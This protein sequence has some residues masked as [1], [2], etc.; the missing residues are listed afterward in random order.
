MD[1]R[2]VDPLLG[3]SS[4]EAAQ[5]QVKRPAQAFPVAEAPSYHEL[6]MLKEPVWTWTIPAYFFVGGAAGAASLLGG[7]LALR[8]EEASRLRRR[9]R[10]LA[11]GGDVISAGLLIYD[12]G[13]PLRFL[14][15]LRVFRPSS[16]MSVGSWILTASGAAN[17]AAALF[18]G[19]RGLLGALGKSGELAGALL[20]MPLA[21]YTA[22]LLSTTAVPVWRESRRTLP[23]LFMS[24]GVAAAAS[25]LELGSLNRHEE[26]VLRRYA[27]AGKAGELAATAALHREAS[28]VPRVARPLRGGASGALLTAATVL[29]ATSLVASLWPGRSRKKRLFG[30]LTGAL[31]SL[32][33]RFAL[34]QAGR[35]SARDPHASFELQRP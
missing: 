6:P 35:A 25:L 20:G 1:G 30:A 22:V 28:R 12:L 26:R 23:L 11:A 14:N 34:M 5:M 16:P 27:I 8:G 10:W 33:L 17:S 2:N 9:A 13:R 4:G 21:G 29:T 24:S 7:A 3:I 31:G 18:A 19:R 32:G 15:M